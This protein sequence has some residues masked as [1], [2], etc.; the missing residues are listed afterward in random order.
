[1]VHGMNGN[2]N[3]NSNCNIDDKAN[4]DENN[5]DVMENTTVLQYIMQLVT[6]EVTTIVVDML[7]TQMEKIN[8]ITKCSQIDIINLKQ[9]IHKL[10][11]NM[12]DFDIYFNK[13]ND[14]NIEWKE[15]IDKKHIK[16]KQDMEKMEKQLKHDIKQQQM[17]MIKI[18]KLLESKFKSDTSTINSLNADC[19]R[20]EKDHTISNRA[21]THCTRTSRMS[22]SNHGNNS[23]VWNNFSKMKYYASKNTFHGK[24]V[25]TSNDY[26]IFDELSLSNFFNEFGLGSDAVQI[27][28]L[29]NISQKRS[30]F[31]IKIK[32]IYWRLKFL[33]I[34]KLNNFLAVTL[35]SHYHDK[36][37]VSNNHRPNFIGVNEWFKRRWKVV[38]R[39]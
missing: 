28:L 37:N 16:L 34:I 30:K 13:K 23:G 27:H 21:N 4:I 38:Q 19:A 22:N 33:Q 3:Y 6:K 9:G 15:N 8:N 2:V 32:S 26:K 12:K 1:M 24:F 29:E 14:S 39:S 18:D 25:L 5:N 7:N 17:E 11:C 31:V 35:F 20:I 36:I 10:S